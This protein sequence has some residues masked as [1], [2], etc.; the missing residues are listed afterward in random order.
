MTKNTD[1]RSQLLARALAEVKR[2]DLRIRIALV[3]TALLALVALIAGAVRENV[4]PEW[5]V[6]QKAYQGLLEE[7]A[8][9]D[10]GKSLAD[11]F[12]IGI[13]QIVVPELGATDRC[14]TCH[15]GLDDPRMSEVPQPHATHSGKYLEWHESSRFGC[16]ICHRGQGRALTFADAESISEDWD[17]P[18]LPPTLTQSGCGLCH[19]ADEVRHQGG[20]LYA[21]GRDL[22]LTRGCYS[23]H[24]LGGRGGTQGPALDGEG[25]KSRAALSFAHV[26]GPHTLAQFLAE[27]FDA[28]QRV[29]PGSRMKP[30]QLTPRENLALT[31]YMLALQD[32]PIPASFLS[33][34][35]H[36]ELARDQLPDESPGAE[37]FQKY[38]GFCHDTGRYG[39]YDKFFGI[40][41]PAVR[42]RGLT[43][44]VTREY[45]AENIR[46][47]RPGTLMP[48]WDKAAGGLADL[49]VERIVDFLLADAVAPE[50]AATS[51]LLTR[52]LDPTLRLGRDAE[53]GAQIYARHCN[54]C[55][56]QAGIGKLGP[57]LAN[58]VFQQT[59]TD[60]LI[61]ATILLGRPDTAMPPFFGVQAMGLD[62]GDVRDLVAYI[63]S[64]VPGD[65]P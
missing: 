53:R 45:L 2:I 55:H 61:Y 13:T 16:T 59:A 15:N 54:S 58:P 35:K 44:L 60:G 33:P 37:L 18:L 19:S 38:C 57:A 65:T 32:R 12:E 56:G 52:T 64:L 22:F 31:T 26:E 6:T 48:P 47:G 8:T 34:G 43:R 23:C 41:M 30:P 20:A 11:R 49:E 5:R 17:Q 7:K 25:S 14:I 62:D 28:P 50:N 63:R 24:K 42:G 40:F 4:L 9:D 36:L 21:E 46:R 51:S 27:H 3:V 29:V 1:K 39:R 10:W